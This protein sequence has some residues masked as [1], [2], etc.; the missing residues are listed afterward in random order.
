MSEKLKIRSL[1]LGPDGEYQEDPSTNP[2]DALT[3]SLE[4]L[5]FQKLIHGFCGRCT[6]RPKDHTFPKRI[7]RNGVEIIVC[8]SESCDMACL[9][10]RF[11]PSK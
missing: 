7:S 4:G 5:S 3:I 9:N 2:C 11:I 6:A 10:R 1:H 8:Q